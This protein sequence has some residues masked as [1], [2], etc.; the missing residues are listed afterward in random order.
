MTPEPC[1]QGDCTMVSIDTLVSMRCGAAGNRRAT[2]RPAVDGREVAD[3][4][5]LCPRA[6]GASFPSSRLH[7]G[8]I[9]IPARLP[10]RIRRHVPAST[11]RVAACVEFRRTNGG[12]T[13]M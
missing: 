2:A 13:A 7:D 6:S 3:R 8:G 11:R 10:H 9:D 5:G 4:T 12:S 1:A